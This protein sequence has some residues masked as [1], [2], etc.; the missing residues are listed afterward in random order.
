MT[1]L[2]Y[3]M[4]G[5]AIFSVIIFF[6][7]KLTN[8]KGGRYQ[9]K[10]IL[11][12]VVA[13]FAIIGYINIYQKKKLDLEVNSLDYLVCILGIIGSASF[14]ALFFIMYF[15]AKLEGRGGKK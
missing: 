6:M 1:E 12:I 8:I 5:V 13:I 3:I 7:E 10:I 15:G 14:L 9:T 2:I 11:A 4:A